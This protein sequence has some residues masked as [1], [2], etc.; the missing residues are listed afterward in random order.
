MGEKAFSNNESQKRY[1]AGV[2]LSKKLNIPITKA[3]EITGNDRYNIETGKYSGSSKMI[4]NLL[5]KS[6]AIK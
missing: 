3:L 6:L 2:K 1:N 5:Q 4:K